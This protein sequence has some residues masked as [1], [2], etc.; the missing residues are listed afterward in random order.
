MLSVSCALAGQAKKPQ[1]AQKGNKIFALLLM[2][3]LKQAFSKTGQL[4]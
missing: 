3:S 4:P 1:Q 2:R